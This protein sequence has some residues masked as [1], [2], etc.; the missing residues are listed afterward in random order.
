MRVFNY[1]NR[2]TIDD[3]AVLQRDIQNQSM[4]DYQLYNSYYTND[5]KCKAMDEF[6][7]ENNMVIKDGY[8]FL[9]QCT[10]DADSDLRLNGVQTNEREKVQLCSRWHQ[11]VPNLN[12]GGLIPN[13]DSRLKNADDTSDIRNCDRVTEHD[14][15]R[16]IPLVGCLAPTIQNPKYIIEPWVRGGAQTR[17]EVRSNEYLNKCGFVSNGKNWVRKQDV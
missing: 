13:I 12:K 16:F 11:G 15:N 6:L 2:L 9:N 3:C 14:F 4:T 1:E 10:V 5:C 17:N 8:G 7:F